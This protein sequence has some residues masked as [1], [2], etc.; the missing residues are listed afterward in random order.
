M[1]INE[2]QKM[3]LKSIKKSTEN[4]FEKKMDWY[5]VDV[6]NNG[7]EEITIEKMANSKIAID[8]AEFKLFHLTTREKK[9]RT[10]NIA[11]MDTENAEEGDW[12][13]NISV[14]L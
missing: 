9:T 14:E 6:A 3:D 13:Y 5:V 12:Y 11:L 4:S 1:K 2:L 7:M 8:E 10:I